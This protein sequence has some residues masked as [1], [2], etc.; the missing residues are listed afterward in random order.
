MAVLLVG[1][2]TVMN[3]G[4]GRRALYASLP[5]AAVTPAIG[6]GSLSQLAA[7]LAGWWDASSPIQLI[8]PGNAPVGTWGAP[9]SALAD[10]SGG[11]QNLL[12]LNT[13][14]FA[15]PQVHPHLSGLLGGAGH[16]TATPG[17]LQPAL[18]PG[19][20]WQIPSSSNNGGTNWTLFLVW[21][22]PNWRQGSNADS[23]PITLVSVGGVPLLQ[24][25]SAGGS[26]R[27]ILFPGAGQTVVAT[28]MTRRH[29]HSIIL[30]FSQTGGS[31]LWLD[32]S[33]VAH[34]VGSGFSSFA[35]PTLLLHDG[36]TLGSAQCWLHE[37]AIW[38]QAISDADIVSVLQ[39]A[40]RW[41]CGPRRGLYFLVNGQ[42]NAVNYSEVDGAAELLAHGVAWHLGAL[43][44]NVLATTTSPTNFTMANGHGIYAIAGTGYPGSF[45]SDP[46]DGSDPSTWLLGA[47]GLAVQQAIDSLPSEDLADMAAIIWPWNETDSLRSYGEYST[48][49]AAAL[50]YLSLLRGMLGDTANKIPLIWWNAIPYG[51]DDGI[52]MHRQAVQAIAASPTENVLIGNPQTSDSNPRGSSWDPSTGVATGG[53]TAHRDSVDNL[54]FAVL[55]APVVAHGLMVSGYGDSLTSIPAILPR[56]GGPAIS[57]VYRSSNTSLILTIAHDS[58]TDL[59]VPLQAATGAGFAV[60]DGG[61]LTNPARR[62]TAVA[63]QR[64]DATHLRVELVSPLQ[65]PSSSCLLFYPYGAEQIGRGNAVTDNFSSVSLPSG[66]QV[67]TQLGSAW[68]VDYPLS[69]TFAGIPLSDT[70]S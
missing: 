67:N 44:Y 37:A 50:R 61:S 45:V 24:I 63:C 16:P 70:P 60:M 14:S 69:A 5:S 19:S 42:S 15:S 65:N 2:N 18:D 25:D 39:Y 21:S 53:D 41:V 43:A 10:L 55:A 27:M 36:K 40:T 1:P 52:T 56:Q 38:T 26:S 8:G 54:R 35:G 51:S 68:N 7:P 49:H 64:I 48:F 33:R 20:G 32:Q 57:H 6:A 13:G 62:V 12:S 22:R 58:G 66:W 59:N 9:G 30:R 11:N 34:G 28:N 23:S 3:V 17:L 4:A 31:D 46:G 29:T 47:D